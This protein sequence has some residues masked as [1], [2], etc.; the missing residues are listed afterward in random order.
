MKKT[1]LIILNK[2]EQKSRVCKHKVRKNMFVVIVKRY[3]VY[4]SVYLSASMTYL[5]GQMGVRP[6]QCLSMPVYSELL[7]LE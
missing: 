4:L 2:T 7:L 1:R 6:V 5:H 3:D